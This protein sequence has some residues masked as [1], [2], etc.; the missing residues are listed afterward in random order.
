M[1]NGAGSSGLRCPYDTPDQPTN[2][3][4]NSPLP[5]LR[6]CS[7]KRYWLPLQMLL[8][9]ILPAATSV[10]TWLADRTARRHNEQHGMPP[11]PVGAA[12]S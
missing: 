9:P 6:L 4:T 5:L 3:P 8:G 2:Q 11:R 1:G 12:T 7:P 10:F